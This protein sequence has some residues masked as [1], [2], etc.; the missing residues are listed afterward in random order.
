MPEMTNEEHK[1]FMDAQIKK[2]EVDK[3]LEGERIGRDPG[4]EYVK[5]WI[6]ERAAKFRKEWSEEETHTAM[7]YN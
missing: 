7:K 5:K 4:D 2:I 6:R 1:E 3:W